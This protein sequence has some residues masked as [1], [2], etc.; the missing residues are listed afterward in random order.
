MATSSTSKEESKE[1]PMSPFQKEMERIVQEKIK[2]QQILDGE[3]SDPEE[4]KKPEKKSI[5]PKPSPK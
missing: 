3:L 5:F 4:S 1:E 2:K